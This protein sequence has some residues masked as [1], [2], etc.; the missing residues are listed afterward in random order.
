MKVFPSVLQPEASRMPEKSTL[1][2]ILEPSLWRS[3]HQTTGLGLRLG[4]RS[5]AGRLFLWG[6][7]LPGALS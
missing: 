5:A 4:H 7:Q 1:A 6:G 2:E 3:T